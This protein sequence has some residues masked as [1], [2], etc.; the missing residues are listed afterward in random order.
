MLGCGGVAVERAIRPAL[1]E[2]L[3]ELVRAWLRREVEPVADL[4]PAAAKH[5]NQRR[6]FPLQLI[7][8]NRPPESTYFKSRRAQP[9][10][11]LFKA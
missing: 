5:L 8:A 3:R 6:K 7:R 11:D 9:R 4:K 10:G 2:D 1:R